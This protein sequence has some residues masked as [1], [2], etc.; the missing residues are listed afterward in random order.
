MM[1][2]YFISLIFVFF[3]NNYCQS[4]VPSFKSTATS[5]NIDEINYL[6][7][8]SNNADNEQHNVKEEEILMKISLSLNQN[9][10]TDKVEATEIILKYLSSFPFSAVL[11][12]QPL[13]YTPLMNAK[14]VKVSFL[15]KKTEEKS[16]QDGGIEFRI[17]VV[18]QNEE[19]NESAR[20]NIVARR[21]SE[22]QFISKIFS[23]GAIIKSFV[24][25]LNH[26]EEEGG[27]VGIGHDKLM[28]I[29][30]IQSIY[31]KWM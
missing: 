19:D 8:S 21:D 7:K 27:R 31:H 26:G 16:S 23:E 14:G 20:I 11:P 30:S 1:R 5:A 6:L 10:N 29:C 18:D 28:Q 25:G 22:G 3:I 24:S 15:R 13:T 17:F 2:R 9:L 12:V 4:F